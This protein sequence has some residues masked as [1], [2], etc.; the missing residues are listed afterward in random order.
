MTWRP[1]SDHASMSS[2]DSESL[3]Q[4]SPGGADV[5]PI[6]NVVYPSYQHPGPL[7][8]PY[9]G[10]SPSHHTQDWGQGS[11]SPH[12][13]AQ[14]PHLTDGVMSEDA[15]S[16]GQEGG[17][18]FYSQGS[19]G[20]NEYNAMQGGLKAQPY[21]TSDDL[22]DLTRLELWELTDDSAEDP[23]FRDPNNS[24]N[25]EFPNNA[26]PG[27]LVDDH[28]RPEEWYQGHGNVLP[29][30]YPNLGESSSM[31]EAPQTSNQTMAGFPTNSSAYPWSPFDM[32]TGEPS[33]N[34]TAG[35]ME[36]FKIQQP[37]PSN[38]DYLGAYAHT[39]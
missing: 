23:V 19:P 33:P 1:D 13:G 39:P 35:S 16:S 9:L 26:T 2:S 15:E 4:G 14:P 8:Q 24:F 30:N 32:R 22:G 31:A 10:L 28:S 20:I 5:F 18:P 37:G 38:G 25:R 17:R 12:S 21:R 3:F 6:Q 29:Q 11:C 27:G 36:A 34:N 7:E